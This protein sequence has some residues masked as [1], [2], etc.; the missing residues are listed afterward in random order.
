MSTAGSFTVRNYRLDRARP[1]ALALKHSKHTVSL[2]GAGYPQLP[3]ALCT[4]RRSPSFT[5]L[6]PGRLPPGWQFVCTPLASLHTAKG[7][8]S[9]CWTS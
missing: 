2:L 1:G 3:P 8:P 9:S 5:L 6:L 7:S 4:L